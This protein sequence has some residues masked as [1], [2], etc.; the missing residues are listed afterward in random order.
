MCII[1]VGVGFLQNLF[2]YTVPSIMSN[3]LS[4]LLTYQYVKKQE[5]LPKAYFA[6]CLAV[7]MAV[8]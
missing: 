1:D 8:V 5:F 2:L 4:F 7:I 3:S 6:C